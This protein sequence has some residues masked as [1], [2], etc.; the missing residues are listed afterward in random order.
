M[1]KNQ[2]I[3]SGSAANGQYKQ[4]IGLSE[5]VIDIPDGYEK[6]NRYNGSLGHKFNHKFFYENCRMSFVSN[7][8]TTLMLPIRL[9]LNWVLDYNKVWKDYAKWNLYY[10]SHN[11][12]KKMF[13][14][15]VQSSLRVSQSTDSEYEVDQKMSKKFS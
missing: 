6:L 5:R 7:S 15:V 9:I 8:T 10:A 12:D 4:A 1:H 3:L 14:F 13:P 11:I 2:K